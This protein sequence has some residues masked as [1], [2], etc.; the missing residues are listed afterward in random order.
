MK[1]ITS[2]LF[3]LLLVL[4]SFTP[5]IDIPRGDADQNGEVNIADV[6]TLIDYLLYGHWP[7]EQPQP[8]TGETFTVNG[9]SFTM[10]EVDGGTFMMGATPESLPYTE[11][12]YMSYVK[13]TPAHEV[14]LSSYSIGQTE[15]T[16]E[17]WRAVMGA[18]PEY[19]A[20]PGDPLRPV[21]MVSWN[22]CQTFIT[23]L[24]QLTG[25]NFRLPTEAEWEFAA[26][27][28][29]Y[30]QGYIYAGSNNRYD[31]AWCYYNAS[32][33][34]HTVGLKLPNELGLY[35]M[36]GNVAEWCQDRYGEYTS[37]AQTDPTGPESGSN[38]IIRGGCYNERVG[39]SLSDW[40][41]SCR[42][43]FNQTSSL[44]YVGLRLAL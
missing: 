33:R 35:D 32:G 5:D 26:R 43:Y 34:T 12:P 2:F 11:A 6:T 42:N 16:Q 13:E 21:E 38:R 29:N 19:L 28:G 31:V 39:A 30:S 24:N 7:G 3:V 23:K 41:V 10:I 37:E 1:K 18:D 4:A 8:T 15:V 25:K 40:R 36:S 27:G 22:N 14:T 17:L 44:Q 9:V 20:F